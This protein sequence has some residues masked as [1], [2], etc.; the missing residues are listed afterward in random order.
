MRQRY[1]RMSLTKCWVCCSHIQTAADGLWNILV[2][3]P[4]FQSVVYFEVFA[5][6]FRGFAP[7]K[8]AYICSSVIIC[9][10]VYHL[11]SPLILNVSYQSFLVFF[12]P[13]KADF[14]SHGCKGVEMYQ[15]QVDYSLRWF[16]HTCVGWNNVQNTAELWR[17]GKVL[18]LSSL[19][20][21]L[22]VCEVQG[23]A[24]DDQYRR[25]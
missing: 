6:H 2:N 1:Q 13:W 18:L 19:Y 23:C 21:D 11:N 12:P 4:K 25:S 20:A 24:V 22:S 17:T 10:K 7:N 3:N 9:P 5:Q 16:I 8:L 15:A 14:L